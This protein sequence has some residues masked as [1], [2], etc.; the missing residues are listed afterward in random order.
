LSDELVRGLADSCPR[1]FSIEIGN[2]DP[3]ARRVIDRIGDRRRHSCNGELPDTLC[4]KRGHR[5][6]LSDEQHVHIADGRVNR[7]D[8]LGQ[9]RLARS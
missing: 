3:R 6:G 5:V 9:R 4:A 1:T 7:D 8:V 2:A